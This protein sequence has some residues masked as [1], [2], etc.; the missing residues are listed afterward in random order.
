MSM[1]K[2]IVRPIFMKKYT[3]S[4][5]YC[6][7]IIDFLLYYL[8]NGGKLIVHSNTFKCSI[9]T[10]SRYKR[11]GIPIMCEALRFVIPTWKPEPNTIYAIDCT[12]SPIC[13]PH[14]GQREFYRGDQGYHFL[15]VQLI[16]DITKFLIVDVI[17]GKGRNNDSGLANISGT[18]DLVLKNKLVILADRGY[19]KNKFVTPNSLDL[20]EGEPTEELVTEFRDFVS[21]NRSCVENANQ[22]FKSLD[23]FNKPIKSRPISHAYT[24]LL[25]VYCK[26]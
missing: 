6:E 20:I 12:T 16:V 11:D 14:P 24:T 5:L 22:R 25:G 23:L 8:I 2:R 19:S 1:V 4:R 18:T 10:L 13:R 9:S 15:G 21:K 7:S 17:I 26:Y 3:K